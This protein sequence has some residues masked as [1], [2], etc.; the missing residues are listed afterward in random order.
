[1]LI[2]VA[3]GAMAFF[4]ILTFVSWR[5]RRRLD[6]HLS[7][8]QRELQNVRDESARR[9]R[10]AREEF[11]EKSLIHAKHLEQVIKSRYAFTSQMT[12]LVFEVLDFDGNC[13]MT[14]AHRGLK[15]GEGL[16]LRHM[17]HNF[18]TTTPGAVLGGVDLVK[19][20]SSEGVALQVISTKPTEIAFNIILPDKITE[21]VAGAD[22]EYRTS[23]Q[24]GAIM[25][26]EEAA[27]K[28]A[29]DVT[30]REGFFHD[31]DLPT[32]LLEL[33]VI[34]PPNY[35]ARC[36]SH[37][38]IGNSWVAHEEETNKLKLQQSGRSAKLSI[39]NPI[40]GFRYLVDWL[41]PTRQE[42]EQIRQG[43]VQS[44]TGGAP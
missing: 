39:E 21:S 33:E 7:G 5:K 17:R 41:G 4:S 12:R 2:A 42:F 43:R 11:E 18:S 29:D 19:R 36:M 8:R 16:S 31:N 9:V 10:V 44:G 20:G 34:F 37:V 27:E 40:Q 26:Q 38:Y 28:Y 32:N 24:K 30:P 3:L 15:T 22:Y 25:T 14:R 1:M 6:Q 35:P 23:V 13:L